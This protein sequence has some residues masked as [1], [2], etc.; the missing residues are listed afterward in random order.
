M[1]RWIRSDLLRQGLEVQQVEQVQQVEHVR[2]VVGQARQCLGL[3]PRR[4]GGILDD[5]ALRRGFKI[6]IEWIKLKN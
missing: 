4:L 3:Q 5:L 1:R 6:E 2:H